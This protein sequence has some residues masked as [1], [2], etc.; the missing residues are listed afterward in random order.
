MVEGI[1]FRFTAEFS[2]RNLA[3]PI[4]SPL[5]PHLF[6]VSSLLSLSFLRALTLS[7]SYS[8]PYLPLLPPLFFSPFSLSPS[9]PLTFLLLLLPH[10]PPPSLPVSL[11]ATRHPTGARGMGGTRRGRGRGGEWK[12]VLIFLIVQW[13]RLHY[14]QYVIITCSDHQSDSAPLRRCWD[15]GDDEMRRQ[16]DEEVMLKWGRWY[17][18]D[19]EMRWWNEKILRW[20]GDDEMRR[21]WDELLTWGGDAE[22]SQGCSKVDWRY[23]DVEVISDAPGS[24]IL[25][26]NG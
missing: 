11:T 18:D 20:G 8:P 16:W 19:I 21:N 12:K 9:P 4:C 14:H 15:G 3:T 1:Y 7:I 22:K 17:W 2:D 25:Q 24:E 13:R 5:F 10:L 23:W 6:S 26:G